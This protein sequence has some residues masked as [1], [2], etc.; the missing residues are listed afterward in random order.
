MKDYLRDEALAEGDSI[1]AVVT[2]AVIFS[3]I[4]ASLAL[5]VS[6]NRPEPKA[7]VDYCQELTQGRMPEVCNG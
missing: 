7:Q 5:G 2:I 4:L 6:L 3:L 1:G